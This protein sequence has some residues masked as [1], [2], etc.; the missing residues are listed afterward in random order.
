MHFVLT[1]EIDELEQKRRKIFQEFKGHERAYN[2]VRKEIVKK[3]N[4]EYKR[5]VEEERQAQ[6][7]A[8]Q[9]EL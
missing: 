7:D 1:S 4:E 2:N 9:R 6:Y 5:R 3:R 8:E